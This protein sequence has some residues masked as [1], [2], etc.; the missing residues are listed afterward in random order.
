MAR[1]K[2][3]RF[4]KYL[5]ASY[6]K[7]ALE[8]LKPPED[9]TPSEWAARYRVLEAKTS[10]LPG[11]W[12][13]EKTPYLVGIMDEFSNYETEEIIFAKPSQVGGT[14]V[15]LNLLGYTIHEDPSDTLVVYPSDELG[16]RTSENRIKP[17]VLASAPLRER[18]QENRS[19]I[20]E[21]S[22][23]MAYT[24]IVEP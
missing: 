24:M 15:I 8:S 20:K 7:K 4:R 2:T 5:V 1:K 9:I 12:R 19:K 23:V 14:E 16:E 11:P 17:M 13:N 18:F 21:E 22:L 3:R 6:L 10:D